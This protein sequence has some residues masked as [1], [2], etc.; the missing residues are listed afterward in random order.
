MRLIAPRAIARRRD[1]FPQGNPA[2]CLNE[3]NNLQDKSLKNPGKSLVN[4]PNHT[5]H[6]LNEEK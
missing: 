6:Q 2:H 4:P 1:P 3:N 5:A